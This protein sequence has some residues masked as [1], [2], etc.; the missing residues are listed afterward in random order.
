M[1]WE[2]RRA[3]AMQ[4][5]W[6]GPNDRS[7]MYARYRCRG[8]TQRP[9]ID[10]TSP[11]GRYGKL[12]W[13]MTFPNF[14]WRVIY[15][16]YSKRSSVSCKSLSVW[17][18]A[19]PVLFRPD[20]LF[21]LD[22]VRGLI[23][24][25]R[26]PNVRA[27]DLASKQGVRMALRRY[28]RYAAHPYAAWAYATNAAWYSPRE[29]MNALV[30]DGSIGVTDLSY[31]RRRWSEEARN[32]PRVSIKLP[33][34]AASWIG[35]EWPSAYAPLGHTTNAYYARQWARSISTRMAQLANT[36]GSSGICLLEHHHM[37]S[38]YATRRWRTPTRTTPTEDTTRGIPARFR[39]DHPLTVLP[40]G[41]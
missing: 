7:L 19:I 20:T 28:F 10:P 2:A 25:I 18:V 8:R 17:C 37:V 38:R 9:H 36:R 32:I 40:V 41:L 1:T 26:V 15:A 22:Q 34:H 16:F 24:A 11:P 35:W 29:L 33:N 27:G 30:P 14:Q 6:S 5:L 39:V 21:P 23:P 3:A 4:M 31:H 12:S 13:E